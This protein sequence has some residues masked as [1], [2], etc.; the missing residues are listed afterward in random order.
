MLLVFEQGS[1]DSA[2]G[3]ESVVVYPEIGGLEQ[4]PKM[5]PEKD[6]PH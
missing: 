4:F 5:I 6:S 3:E 1:I 2:C